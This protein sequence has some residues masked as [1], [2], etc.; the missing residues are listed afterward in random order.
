M[1]TPAN[2]QERA[3]VAE[4]AKAVEEVMGEDPDD[5]AQEHGIRLEVRA[6]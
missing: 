4:L 1:V 6:G 3:Q 2:E 5:Q